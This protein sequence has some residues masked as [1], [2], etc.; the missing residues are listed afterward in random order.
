[1]GIKQHPK[2]FSEEPLGHIAETIND[3]IKWHEFLYGNEESRVRGIYDKMV[4][5]FDFLQGWSD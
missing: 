2:A 3:I 5:D 4:L 1:M